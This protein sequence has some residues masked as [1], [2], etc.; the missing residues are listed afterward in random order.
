MSY[1][2]DATLT[3]KGQVTVP[4]GIRDRLGVKPGDQL[5][6]HLADSGRLTV[7]PIRRRSIFERLDELELPALGHPLGKTEIAQAIGDA[8]TERYRRGLRKRSR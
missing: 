8:V 1:K 4:A 7:T 2:I 6:F 3:S 5:R